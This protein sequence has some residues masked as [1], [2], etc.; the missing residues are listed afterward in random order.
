MDTCID[1][2]GDLELHQ[3]KD[4][5]WIIH[6]DDPSLSCSLLFAFHE[7]FMESSYGKVVHFEA[8]EIEQIE[9]WFE[10]YEAGGDG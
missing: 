7:H 4:G 3:D 9:R 2:H 6:A 1:T 10:E 5:C 8:D